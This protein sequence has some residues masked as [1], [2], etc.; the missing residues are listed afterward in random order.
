M[1]CGLILMILILSGDN[2]KSKTISN[3]NWR[4]TLLIPDAVDVKCTFKKDTANLTMEA[5]QEV[6][7]LVFSQRNDTLIVRKV[8]GPGP[9]SEQVQGICRIE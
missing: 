2:L 1:K 3:S 5:G 4:G 7:T 8:S 6:G 9:C